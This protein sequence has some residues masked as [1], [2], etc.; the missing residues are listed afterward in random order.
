MSL[1][2]VGGDHLPD[3]DRQRIGSG[4]AAMTR[5]R[6][7]RSDNPDGN[8]RNRAGGQ[9][10]SGS[11]SKWLKLPGRRALS[12]REASAI[13]TGNRISVVRLPG[14]GRSRRD[15]RSV[16]GVSASSPLSQ[17]LSAVDPDRAGDPPRP[18]SRT[19]FSPDR[20]D[21]GKSRQGNAWGGLAKGRLLLR[22]PCFFQAFPDSLVVRDWFEY[23]W[24]ECQYL[25]VGQGE[26]RFF[27]I[28]VGGYWI[29]WKKDWNGSG[30]PLSGNR[31]FPRS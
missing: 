1:K 25:L 31:W 19:S 17:T 5:I 23:P 11:R 10:I 12:F 8:D 28:L 18:V 27:P 26:V 14:S 4:K 6:L 15:Y 13:S 30:E 29:C 2:P 20:G 3:P 22:F 9:Q 24:D 16:S 7:K 21:T